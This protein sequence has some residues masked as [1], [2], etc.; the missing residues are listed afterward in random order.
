MT[1][2][3]MKEDEGA[4]RSPT[5]ARARLAGATP[6]GAREGGAGEGGGPLRGRGGL[7]EGRGTPGRSRGPLRGHLRGRRGSF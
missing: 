5:S 6:G 4:T 2:M 7:L 3:K 1:N